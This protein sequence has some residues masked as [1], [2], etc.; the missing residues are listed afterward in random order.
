MPE[1]MVLV[2]PSGEPA[3]TTGWPTTS[4]AE[5]PSAIGVSATAAVCTLITARSGARVASHDGG[6]YLRGT[7]GEVD[8]DG[9]TRSRGLDHIVVG[10]NVALAVERRPGADPRAGRTPDVD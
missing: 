10:Q 3:A 5:F 1:V 4:L 2:S 9:G 6:R 7:P 8:G